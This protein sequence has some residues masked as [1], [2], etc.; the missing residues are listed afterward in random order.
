MPC[1]TTGRTWVIRIAFAL[2]VACLVAF[3]AGAG[4]EVT[5]KV[6]STIGAVAG[7]T[8]LAIAFLFPPSGPTASDAPAPG[9][10]DSDASAPGA[11]APGSPASGTSAG[12]SRDSGSA[13]EGSTSAGSSPPPICVGTLPPLASAFQPRAGLRDR[14]QKA[15]N[16]GVDVILSQ[17]ERPAEP[18]ARVLAGGGGVGKSQLAAWFA[19]TAINDRDAELVVRVVA[20]GPDQIL[21]TY[22]RA[23]ARVGAPG[24]LGADEEADAAAFLEWLQI[25]DRTWLIILDDIARA[26]DLTGWWPPARPNG[27]TL[28]T[29]RLQDAAV[30]GSGRQKIDIDVYAPDES[31]ASRRP[32]MSRSAAPALWPW[33]A[34]ARCSAAP[35]RRP[36]R[37]A[38]PRA[39]AA[40]GRPRRRCV[41]AGTW[42]SPAAAGR[43]RPGRRGAVR[44][45]RRL[46]RSWSGPVR[47]SRE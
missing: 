43:G 30:T 13:R 27:W 45:L 35:S 26:A 14:I 38:R 23:A 22:A 36:A 10:P 2:T 12:S 40:S 18:T 19:H 5:D 25:P 16:A 34:A 39:T 33:P 15:R 17:E 8:A 7:L 41:T 46:P 9:V 20:S 3:F 31:A 47:W 44:V 11:S 29:T 24:A 21:H 32:V 1:R 6:S 28:A 4:L 42:T 37:R